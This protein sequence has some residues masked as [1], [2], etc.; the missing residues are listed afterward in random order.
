MR[1]I[2]YVLMKKPG[3]TDDCLDFMKRHQVNLVLLTLKTSER[4]T[5][6]YILRCLVAVFCWQF[7]C[8]DRQEVMVEE[9]VGGCFFLQNEKRQMIS[10]DNANSRLKKTLDKLE[11]AGMQVNGRDQRFAYDV[12]YMHNN[13]NL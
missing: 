11:R 9:W 12:I 5:E 10:V 4:V 7:D 6:M 3:N 13:E 8:P 2:G 1:S